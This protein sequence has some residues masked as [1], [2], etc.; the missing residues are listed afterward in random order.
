MSTLYWKWD[1]E[2]SAD[3]LSI[4]DAD[5]AAAPLIDGAIADANIDHQVR[6]S[7]LSIH[8]PVYWLN[9]VLSNYS[10]QANI[11]AGWNRQLTISPFLQY[12][13]YGEGQF[14]TWH[15][16]SIALTDDPYQRKLTAILMVSNRTDYEGGDLE[17]EGQ[18]P[19]EL[20]RGS[21]IVFPS[22]LRHR[23]TPVTR[24]MRITA[25]NWTLGP[26]AW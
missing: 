18:P 9:A 3:L 14:Y 19:I 17:I 10:Q 12:A 5:I 24:G 21:I 16:D 20:D 6:N 25:V 1:R 11:Q 4:V 13:R 26:T 22:L 7:T 8:G 2:L 23:V 15:A